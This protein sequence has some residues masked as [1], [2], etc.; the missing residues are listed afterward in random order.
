MDVQLHGHPRPPDDSPGRAPPVRGAHGWAAKDQ[1]GPRH[2]FKRQLKKSGQLTRRSGRGGLA[3]SSMQARA[4]APACEG[5]GRLVCV[6]WGDLLYILTFTASVLLDVHCLVA[7]GRHADLKL[8]VL[9]HL[10]HRGVE[11]GRDEGFLA[12]HDLPRDAVCGRKAP[13]LV[14]VPDDAVHALP[15]HAWGDI[16]GLAAALRTSCKLEGQ[17]V[18]DIRQGL[19]LRVVPHPEEDLRVAGGGLQEAPGVRRGLDLDDGPHVLLRG[20]GPRRRRGGGRKPAPAP[21]RLPRGCRR[22]GE[23][24]AAAP[25][26]ALDVRGRHPV[27]LGGLGPPHNV[28]ADR[29]ARLQRLAQVR[30]VPRLRE[31]VAGDLVRD[32]EAPVVAEPLDL[33][34][35]LA[36]GRGAGRAGPVAGP[37][38]SGG[39]ASV[40][41]GQTRRAG[42]GQARRGGQGQTRRGGQGQTR[43]TRW[44]QR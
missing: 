25:A 15:D 33:A 2:R 23:R 30:A 17:L 12:N 3:A 43:R 5:G 9:A 18:A 31:D 1:H 26:Q 35:V 22:R 21:P 38:L 28:E 4:R 7:L 20:H 42:Q 16:D 10:Q 27:V 41:Q 32:Q 6:R 40:G 44:R 13:T 36:P 29:L 8:D 19:E 11:P 14:D 39:T 34:H 24:R 37:G